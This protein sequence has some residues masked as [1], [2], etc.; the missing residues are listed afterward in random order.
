MSYKNK[1]ADIAVRF[2]SSECS[3]KLQRKNLHRIHKCPG[4]MKNKTKF[5]GRTKVM[6]NPSES[7]RLPPEHKQ[8]RWHSKIHNINPD[9][10]VLLFC[11]TNPPFTH[12][13]Q[14]QQ[15]LEL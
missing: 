14:T 8:I 6:Q 9:L 1:V 10:E 3:E 4:R 2:L 5:P 13:L 12:S 7:S 11:K 15:I